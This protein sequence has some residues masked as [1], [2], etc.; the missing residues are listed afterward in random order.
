ME[1]TFIDR[2]FICWLVFFGL[3]ALFGIIGLLGLGIMRLR[4]RRTG[5]RKW[6]VT[7]RS[8]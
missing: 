4:D 2:L 6:Y 5:K 3:W 8:I 7:G 1:L